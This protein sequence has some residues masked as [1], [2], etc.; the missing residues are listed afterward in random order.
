M[1][2]AVKLQV[3]KFATQ[4]HHLGQFRTVFF[5]KA[6]FIFYQRLEMCRWDTDAPAGIA[7]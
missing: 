4:S 1:P 3:E 5:N 7:K 2:F 6:F